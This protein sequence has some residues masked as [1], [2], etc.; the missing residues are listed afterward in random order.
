[1]ILTKRSP[2]FFAT[3][4]L[5]ASKSL[6]NRW[7]VLNACLDQ[8]IK[9]HNLSD[10][11]DTV[12]MQELLNKISQ[13]KNSSI[14][15]EINCENAGTVLRF[16]TAYLSATSG[17]WLVTGDERLSVRPIDDLV[18]ALKNLGA[19]IFYET[20]FEQLPLLIVGKPDFSQSCVN[21]N[22]QK[23]SQFASALML[24]ISKF[25]HGLRIDFD[26]EIISKPYF[27][28]TAKI[29]E[30]CG[31]HVEYS[32][33][34]IIL[35]GKPSCPQKEIFIESD[36]SAA[37]YF[38]A[39]VALSESGIIEIENLYSQSLQGDSVLAK[40][41]EKFGV[42]TTFTPTKTIIKKVSKS[43]ISELELDFRDY[44]DLAQTLAVVCA[45]LNISARLTGLSS[46][47]DK[48]TNR[49]DALSQELNQIGAKNSIEQ[50]S[51]ILHKHGELDFSNPTKTYD[52]HR[53]AM[54]FSIFSGL[55][56]QIKIDS[57]EVVNKSFPKFWEQLKKLKSD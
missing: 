25:P 12:L 45:A 57:P 23:S 24:M 48:E 53:M 40:W 26:G 51:L 18:A 10:A 32:E 49:L 9:L 35:N 50:N 1:M 6:S 29:L 2:D 39:F 20:Q 46:L 11:A 8:K 31:V 28:M 54:A 21:L 16:L 41:F 43:L 17:K 37:S 52:D 4:E 15:V 3:I 19:E 36:W 38:Y 14:P 47:R 34:H 33:K 13:S 22:M 5:P 55:Y 44:P 27:E 42:E 30:Q 56:D 7:L